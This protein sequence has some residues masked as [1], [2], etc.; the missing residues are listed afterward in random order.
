MK[1]SMQENGFALTVYHHVFGCSLII[2]FRLALKI[3]IKMESCGHFDI[4]ARPDS[5]D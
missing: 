1:F 5:R 4:E 2:F 3:T